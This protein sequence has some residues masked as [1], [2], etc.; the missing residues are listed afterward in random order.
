V[1]GL[2]FWPSLPEITHIEIAADKTSTFQKQ[3]RLCVFVR[4]RERVQKK[5]RKL[6]KIYVY[7]I[8]SKLNTEKKDE[9][10]G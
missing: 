3:I 7:I 6:Q 4:K 1:Y 2:V 8:Y 5:Q 10:E 9:E